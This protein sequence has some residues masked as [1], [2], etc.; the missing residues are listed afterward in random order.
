MDRLRL[1]VAV[2]PASPE[3]REGE[4]SGIDI[5]AVCTALRA[6][7]HPTSELH[8]ERFAEVLAAFAASVNLAAPRPRTTA[9]GELPAPLPDDIARRLLFACAIIFP[10][11]DL[12]RVR[13]FIHRHLQADGL[14]RLRLRPA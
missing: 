11:G 8:V 10:E 2:V 6:E 5:D 12:E 14:L 3:V 7:V 13:R 1:T 9:S 4:D